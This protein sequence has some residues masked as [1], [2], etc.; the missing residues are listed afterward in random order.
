MVEG[1]GRT[2]AKDE[3]HIRL[4][5]NEKARTRRPARSINNERERV[6]YIY[7]SKELRRE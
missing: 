1:G 5:L 3:R 7:T 4:H 2:K 6:K